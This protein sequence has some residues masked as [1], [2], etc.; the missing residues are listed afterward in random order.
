VRAGEY[1]AASDRLGSIAL[2]AAEIPTQPP[3]VRKAADSL[4]AATVPPRLLPVEGRPRGCERLTATEAGAGAAVEPGS[5]LVADAAA[6]LKLRR[7][8]DEFSI[9][10]GELSAG[11]PASLLLPTD[12]SSQPWQATTS[13][14]QPLKVCDP[15]SPTG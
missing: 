11:V 2:P 1:L 4:L 12:S 14:P 13:P 5:V 10:A 6:E 7:F 15:V 3:S 8:A 9:P